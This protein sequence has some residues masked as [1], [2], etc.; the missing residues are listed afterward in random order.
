MTAPCQPAGDRAPVAAA[1][2]TVLVVENDVV[3]GGLVGVVLADAGYA[4]T[5]L[6]DTRPAAVRAAVDRLE[7]ACVLLDGGGWRGYGASW[8]LAAWMRGRTRSVPAVMFTVDAGATRDAR[9]GTSARSRAAGFAAVLP[10]PFDL[11]E[12]LATVARAGS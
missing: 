5:V 10:K 2:R 4:A 9:A 8:E 11:D 6:L 3:L 1:P 12:L 7:P